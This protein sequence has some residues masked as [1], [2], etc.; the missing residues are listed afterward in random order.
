[1]PASTDHAS[2][3]E[4][5]F[6]E[7]RKTLWALAYR[8][9]GSHEDAEDVV[10]EAFVRLLRDPPCAPPEELGRWLARVGH[11]AAPTTRS[12]LF[13]FCCGRQVCYFLHRCQ[14]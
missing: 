4:Q 5:L 11:V 7:Q 10:Q 9:T 12:L 13:Y 6:R 14:L 8:L 1:M 3:L 2:L